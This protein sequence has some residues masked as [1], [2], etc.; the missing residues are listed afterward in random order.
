MC[1][2]EW[3]IWIVKETPFPEAMFERICCCI[4][5]FYEDKIL[6]FNIKQQWVSLTYVDQ[7]NLIFD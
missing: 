2:S 6:V 7:Q 4:L 1:E 3:G 5:N